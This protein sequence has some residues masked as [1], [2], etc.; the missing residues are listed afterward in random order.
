MPI[1]Q[2]DTCGVLGVREWL[3]LLGSKVLTVD[4]SEARYMYVV[5]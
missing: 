4:V 3:N 5:Y 1:Y 2:R